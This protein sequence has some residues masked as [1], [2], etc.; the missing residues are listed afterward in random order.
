MGIHQHLPAGVLLHPSLRAGRCWSGAGP[1]QQQSK[2]QS[3][4]QPSTLVLGEGWRVL[5]AP[6][7]QEKGVQSFW[8]W[9]WRRRMELCHP[10][11]YLLGLS[12]SHGAAASLGAT[13]LPVDVTRVSPV[14]QEPCSRDEVGTGGGQARLI[15]SGH[16]ATCFSISQG[17]PQW[18]SLGSP[19]AVVK[20][21]PQCWGPTTTV[22]S[23][24][25][26]CGAH[27]GVHAGP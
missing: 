23:S 18:D 5:G 16:Q 19:S 12:D 1:G 11:Q 17:S 22:P 3:H 9:G 21:Q 4:H 14:W 10:Q 13:Q 27:C 8:A 26:A 24:W 25:G 15:V 2:G 6:G 7:E 20:P